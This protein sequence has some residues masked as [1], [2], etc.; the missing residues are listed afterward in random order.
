MD[1]WFWCFGAFGRFAIYCAD[2]PYFLRGNMIYKNHMITTAMAKDGRWY[3]WIRPD[4]NEMSIKKSFITKGPAG[5]DTMTPL[6]QV[7]LVLALLSALIFICCSA[8]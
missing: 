3:I 7:L 8:K 1:A 6:A 4:P 2:A 5:F